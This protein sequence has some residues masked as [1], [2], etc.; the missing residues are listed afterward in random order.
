[1]STLRQRLADAPH[2]DDTQ[3]LAVHVGA[4]LRRADI[5]RPL[6]GANHVGQFHDTPGR[7]QDQCETGV[8]GGFGEHVRGVA[9]QD[10]PL[11]QVIDVVIVDAHGNAGDRFKVRRQVQQRGIQF[12]AG[13]EQAVSPGQ[14]FAQLRQAVG[15][16]AFDQGHFSLRLQARHQQR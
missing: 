2:A 14:G 16:E 3:D 12:Q 15:V 5:A 1:M 11:G 6:A 10:S 7:R 13:T 4:E 9:E 8:G